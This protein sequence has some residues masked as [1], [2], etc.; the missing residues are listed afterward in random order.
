MGI[1]LTAP[2]PGLVPTCF[3][4]PVGDAAQWQQGAH[5]RTGGVCPGD[6]PS[7]KLPTQARLGGG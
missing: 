1:M 6:H 5:S 3:P 2:A 7:H 4:V